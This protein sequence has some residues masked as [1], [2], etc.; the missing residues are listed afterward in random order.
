MHVICGNVIDPIRRHLDANGDST[1]VIGRAQYIFAMG[2][3]KN[4]MRQAR[5]EENWEMCDI[6]ERAYELVGL[7]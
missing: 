1:Q 2:H 5:E 7:P 6:L 3:W 4:R